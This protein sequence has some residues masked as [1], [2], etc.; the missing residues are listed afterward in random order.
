MPTTCRSRV[1]TTCRRSRVPTTCRLDS[2]WI[3]VFQIE[4]MHVVCCFNAEMMELWD[5]DY[6]NTVCYLHLGDLVRLPVEPWTEKSYGWAWM[7]FRLP[8]GAATIRHGWIHPEVFIS[9]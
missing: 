9:M 4:W 7:C 1:P 8:Y 5:P 6:V 2:V 3:Q